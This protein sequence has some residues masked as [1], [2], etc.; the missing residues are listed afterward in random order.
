MLTLLA[1]GCA[2]RRPPA[3]PLEP[4]P[5]RVTA[6]YRIGCPDVLEV[7]FT[8][9]PQFDV[10]ATVDL[11]G[12]LPLPGVG[13]P[14]V[15][16]LTADEARQM[17][18]HTG[19][20]EVDSVGV[21]VA[22]PRAARVFVS[23]PDNHRKRSFHYGG[24]EPVWDFLQRT[25][26]V[27][28]AESQLNRVYVLRSNVA[29]GTPPRLFHVDVEAIVIDG[30]A[31]TNLPLEAGDHVYIGESRRSSF[32]RVLPD[33]AKPLYRRLTGLLPDSWK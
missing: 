25:H 31:V 20:L 33:W 15:E 5:D 19:Q 13:R 4:V 6:D 1:V 26:S 32:S 11:D 10:Q 30:D 23:G 9:R 2:A 21:R 3:L 16:G 14:R 17:I 27:P 22:A 18:A 24:A 8:D 12:R 7:T 29:D 28:A